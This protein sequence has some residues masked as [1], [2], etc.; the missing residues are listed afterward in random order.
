[1]PPNRAK[2][3]DIKI[4]IL[5]SN[6]RDKFSKSSPHSKQESSKLDTDLFERDIG[7]IHELNP[8]LNCNFK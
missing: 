3:T 5:E 7:E 4:Q 2:V 6:E 8:L 1:M